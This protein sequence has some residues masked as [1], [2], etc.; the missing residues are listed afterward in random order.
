MAG[1]QRLRQ[2]AKLAP[3]SEV[4]AIIRSQQTWPPPMEGSSRA[5]LATA[6]PSCYPSGKIKLSVL[7]FLFS[8]RGLSTFYIRENAFLTLLLFSI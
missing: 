2:P 1:T 3:A 5:M 4:E 8:E 6:R 7:T